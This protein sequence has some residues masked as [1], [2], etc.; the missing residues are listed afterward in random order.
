MDYRHAR[1][2]RAGASRAR[3]PSS[4]SMSPSRSVSP[5][6]DEKSVLVSL[7]AIS[8]LTLC[9][10]PLLRSDKRTSVGA[11]HQH[12]MSALGLLE[13]DFCLAI[14]T[15]MLDSPTAR[16]FLLKPV[17]DEI[18]SDPPDTLNITL[19]RIPRPT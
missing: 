8:G 13:T 4:D 14:G 2:L 19:I 16:L 12:A 10:F 1:A 15:H 6:P 17:L 9:S 11:L 3:A 5:S 7:R 18:D